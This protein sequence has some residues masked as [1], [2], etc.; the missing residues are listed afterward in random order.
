MH[1]FLGLRCQVSRNLKVLLAVII[2]PGLYFCGRDRDSVLMLSI[3]HK[4]PIHR[5][6]RLLQKVTSL[7]PLR[8]YCQKLT[9]RQK[10]GDVILHEGWMALD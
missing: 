8:S 1:V 9:R 10:V 3:N 5:L 2:P 7:W 6:D 4:K